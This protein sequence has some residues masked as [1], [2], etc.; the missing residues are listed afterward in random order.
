MGQTGPNK[1]IQGKVIPYPIPYPIQYPSP[2]IAYPLS[3][4]GNHETPLKYLPSILRKFLQ[5]SW[6]S[7]GKSLSH[8]TDNT[9]D[10]SQD[11]D[12]L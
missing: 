11:F 12:S 9:I 7:H 3:P 2:L 8:N 4:L 6:L 10:T 1:V 5:I